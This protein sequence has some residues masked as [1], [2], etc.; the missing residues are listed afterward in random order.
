[1]GRASVDL[2][3]NASALLNRLSDMGIDDVLRFPDTMVFPAIGIACD[4]MARTVVVASLWQALGR[5]PT[6]LEVHVAAALTGLSFVG[7][8]APDVQ[9]SELAQQVRDL[10]NGLRSDFDRAAEEIR[11]SSF[12]LQMPL[13]MPLGAAALAFHRAA[14][15]G[16]W[17]AGGGFSTQASGSSSAPGTRAKRGKK[18]DKGKDKELAGP[19]GDPQ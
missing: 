4:L 10:A 5:M 11:A 13:A 19:A 3:P 8:I 9:V 14:T 18:Q 6:P 2:Q 16:E 17:T 7:D 12:T 15:A 1:M